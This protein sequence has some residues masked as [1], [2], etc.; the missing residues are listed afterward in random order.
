MPG[1][2]FYVAYGLW[3][4]TKDLKILNEKIFQS[5]NNVKVVRSVGTASSVFVFDEP[6]CV[7]KCYDEFSQRP[8][9]V[10][11]ST[12]RNEALQELSD[13]NSTNRNWMVFV[14]NEYGTIFDGFELNQERLAELYGNWEQEEELERKAALERLKRIQE[15]EALTKKQKLEKSKILYFRVGNPPL[16][17]KELNVKNIVLGESVILRESFVVQTFPLDYGGLSFRFFTNCSKYTSSG[18]EHGEIIIQFE[19]NRMKGLMEEIKS[20]VQTLLQGRTDPITSV[21]SMVYIG[22]DSLLGDEDVHLH[23]E[24][25]LTDGTGN[26]LKS[27]QVVLTKWKEIKGIIEIPYVVFHEGK[28]TIRMQMVK[29]VVYN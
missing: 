28:L 10:E 4:P 21:E 8:E 6:S 22:K 16:K 12:P 14:S 13:Y 20:K 17:M 27:H 7:F 2:E 23:G 26:V 25:L 11:F 9:F 15:D 29:A 1:T 5:G 3:L 24:Q 18:N 19:D